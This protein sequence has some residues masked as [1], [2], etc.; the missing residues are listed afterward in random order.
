[1]R[2]VK[3]VFHPSFYIKEYIEELEITQDEFSKRLG[4]SGKQVSLILKEDANITPDIALKLSLLM[5][6]SVELWL[7]LQSN[8]DAYIVTLKL[9]EEYEN[10]KKIYKMID[11]KF[12]KQL[13]IIND[14]DNIAK[15]IEKLRRQALVSSLSLLSSSL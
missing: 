12:L 8:Y 14:D 10:E 6:T 11:K 5:G 1:M 2:K 15:G 4:I 3:R 9:E 13:K 7:N